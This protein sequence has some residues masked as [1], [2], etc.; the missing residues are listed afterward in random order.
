[1][2]EVTRV[3]VEKKPGFDVE[4]KQM[5]WDLRHNLG[6]KQIEGL[7]L[8]NRYD[9]SGLSSEQFEAAKRTVFSELKIPRGRR[10]SD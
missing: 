7:R 8:L 6:L 1:M 10:N 5:L 9:V 4:A 3:F 2:S